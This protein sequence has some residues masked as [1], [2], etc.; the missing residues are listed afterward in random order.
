MHLYACVSKEGGDGEG[1]GSLS[2]S[3]TFR[4]INLTGLVTG[5]VSLCGPI[6]SVISLGDLTFRL[7]N[8][9]IPRNW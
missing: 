8:S 1:M 6:N 3:D 5:L 2:L 4:Y 7:F 9:E